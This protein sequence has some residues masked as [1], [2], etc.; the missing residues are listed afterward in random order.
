MSVILQRGADWFAGI[1]T[2]A[3]AGTKVISLSGAVVHPYTVEVPF[4][5]T[6]GAIIE[7]IGGGVPDGLA[8]K[9]AQF[10][11]PTGAYLIADDLGLAIDYDTLRAAG[12]IMGSGT[13]VVIT[14]D[15]CAVEMAE[16]AMSYV[17]TQSCG[18]CVFCRE[19]TLQISEILKDIASG[20]GRAQDLD[21]LAELGE[22]MKVSSI[23]A[24]GR[25][26][27]NPVLTSMKLFRH[28]YEAHI[29]EKRCP[30]KR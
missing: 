13:I 5:T 28:E 18:K 20:E 3:N 15:T 9:A 23:C 16:N 30:G 6:I 26:A 21:L 17:Q 19:G 10:G 27:A 24:L 7:E 22:A 11:G 25:S 29:K 8:V 14:D 2:A 4:G 12:F 1:G